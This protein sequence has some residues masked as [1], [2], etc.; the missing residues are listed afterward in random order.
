MYIASPEAGG[1]KLQRKVGLVGTVTSRAVYWVPP[2]RS[3]TMATVRY[4]V[5][6]FCMSS[7]KSRQ[8]SRTITEPST[9]YWW[10]ERRPRSRGRRSGGMKAHSSSPV[11][12]VYCQA[13]VGSWGWLVSASPAS[14]AWSMPSL[15]PTSTTRLRWL[16][17]MRHDS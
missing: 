5:S 13:P 9:M 16:W 1:G 17:A 8:T 4:S 14:K 3:P 6:C 2:V 7:L 11:P 15:A 12:A 10:L